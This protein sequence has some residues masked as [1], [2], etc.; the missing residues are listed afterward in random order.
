MPPRPGLDLNT[1]LNATA[2]LADDIGLS[3]VTL[4][5]LAERLGVKTP[6]LYNHVAGLEGLKLKL[7]IFGV[8]ELT[9]RLSAAAIGRSKDDAVMAV[10]RAYRA[11]A[12][13]RPGLYEA[14]LHSA[15]PRDPELQAAIEGLSEIMHKVLAPYGLGP[16]ESL[17]AI[18]ALRSMIHGFVSLKAAGFFS[19]KPVPPED[20][21]EFLAAIF[22]AGFHRTIASVPQER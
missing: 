17:H 12:E 22:L 7:A 10:F 3:Q 19:G 21:F 15:A 18:R 2:N 6:S 20:S 8:R 16:E 5:A 14:I 1:I 4:A 11:F 9:A 13:E